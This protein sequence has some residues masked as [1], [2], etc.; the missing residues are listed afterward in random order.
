MAIDGLGNIFGVPPVKKEQETGR[1]GQKNE[2]KRPERGPKKEKD[3]K[4]KEGRVDIRI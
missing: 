2:K 4:E 3:E 1:P